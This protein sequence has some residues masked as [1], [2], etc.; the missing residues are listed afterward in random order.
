MQQ[1]ITSQ[2]LIK[3]TLFVIVSI[4]IVT[5]KTKAQRSKI[6]Y[7]P[8]SVINTS[9]HYNGDTIIEVKFGRS[10]EQTIFL[11]YLDFNACIFLDYLDFSN[12]QFSKNV[13]FSFAKFMKN[14]D[15]RM[16]QFS[17]RA[18]FLDAQFS[19]RADFF[20]TQFSRN[21]DFSGAKFLK[22][23][24]EGAQFLD[25]ADFSSAE[26]QDNLFIATQFSE[27]A[28]FRSAYF[29]D[30]ANFT[31]TQFVKDA[32]FT[33]T[34]FVKAAD[35]QG[36]QFSTRSIFRNLKL[37]D[38]SFL[39]FSNAI[40]ADTL[41]FSFNNRIRNEIDLTDANFTD[42]T[43]Y[44]SKSDKYIKP[45][46]VYLYKTDISKF[47]LD[48]IHFRLL[49]PD[50]TLDEPRYKKKISDD[51][52]DAMYEALLNTFREH[53]QQKSYQILDIEYQKF[54]WNYSWASFLTWLP[55]YWWNFGYDK[56]YVFL[57]TVGF[58]IFFT[59]INFFFLNYLNEK[60]YA[61]ENI[62]FLPQLKNINNLGS[63]KITRNNVRKRMWYSFVYTSSIFFRLTLKIE[64]IN[65]QKIGG[66]IYLII[67][68]TLGLICL[69]YMANFVL[70]K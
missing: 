35:F 15:F 58:I 21:A 19:K 42:S 16:A 24:L 20:W 46:F 48:Y 33:N 30:D 39:I 40:L 3:F 52:K 8:D 14:A 54:K 66:A 61:L 49:L 10:F 43:R 22:F 59:V 64:K 18:I 60:V 34:K 63:V 12:A 17:E 28:D 47:H 27:Y 38:S 69:A 26:F 51:E 23:Y 56:E 29:L 6:L 31:G 7:L 53:G 2:I 68:Y 67:M 9:L 4:C 62:P 55:V 44:N 36:V 32:D 57:W 25:S 5:L 11:D 41:D 65:F 37:S 45:H 70:Q 1:K 50:S 13:D